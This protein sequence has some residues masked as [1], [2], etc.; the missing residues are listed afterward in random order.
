MND[1]EQLKQLTVRATGATSWRGEGIKY[2]RNE[3]YLDVEEYMNVM[4]STT[5]VGLARG[6]QFEMLLCVFL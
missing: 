1:A 4:V 2:K 6:N 5:G 3:V